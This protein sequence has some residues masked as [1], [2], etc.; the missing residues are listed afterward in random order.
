[1]LLA[2]DGTTARGDSLRH[3]RIN[4]RA[5]LQPAVELE[6]EHRAVRH[7]ERDPRAALPVAIGKLKSRLLAR[8]AGDRLHAR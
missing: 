5:K 3:T 7:Y 2:G 8:P 4:T 1:M 6:F